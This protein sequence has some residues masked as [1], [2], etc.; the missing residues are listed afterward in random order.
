MFTASQPCY[1]NT[2]GIYVYSSKSKPERFTAGTPLVLP[3]GM[4]SVYVCSSKVNQS[5]Y[6]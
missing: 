4:D 1:P 5:V 2:G 3:I 6:G